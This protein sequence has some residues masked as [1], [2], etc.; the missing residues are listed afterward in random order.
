MLC[1]LTKDVSQGLCF[2]GELEKVFVLCRGV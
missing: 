2:P 1:R